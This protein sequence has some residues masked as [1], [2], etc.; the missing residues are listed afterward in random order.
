MPILEARTEFFGT[1]VFNNSIISPS[2]LYVKSYSF[3]E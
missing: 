2:P 3:Y 1:C